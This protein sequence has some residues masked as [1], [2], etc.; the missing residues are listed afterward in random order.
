MPPFRL[1]EEGLTKGAGTTPTAL[2]NA[3]HK[4]GVFAWCA[5]FVLTIP[6]VT[7]DLP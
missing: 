5:T 3:P 2:W 6:A 7:L 4:G 1:Q